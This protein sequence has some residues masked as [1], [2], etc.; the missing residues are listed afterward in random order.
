M[1]VPQKIAQI[2]HFIRIFTHSN[3]LFRSFL[4]KLISTWFLAIET[5]MLQY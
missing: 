5:A 4:L 3:P 1:F 2:D